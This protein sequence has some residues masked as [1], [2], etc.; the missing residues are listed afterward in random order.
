MKMIQPGIE[1]ASRSFSRFDSSRNQKTR[2]QRTNPRFP[3]DVIG[4]PFVEGF[5]KPAQKRA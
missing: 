3:S 4:E 2:H 5:N 1:K